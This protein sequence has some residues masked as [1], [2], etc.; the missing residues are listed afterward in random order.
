M[1]TPVYHPRIDFDD[2]A[3]RLELVEQVGI[4]EYNR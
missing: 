1:N 3:A 2:P 4:P